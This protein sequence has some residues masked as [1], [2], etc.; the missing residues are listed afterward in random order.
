M[1][2]ILHSPSVEQNLHLHTT[3]NCT[4][5]PLSP[6]LHCG[7]PANENAEEVVAYI[8]VSPPLQA[9]LL[10]ALP[11]ATAFSLLLLHIT[12]FEH[13]PM[14]PSATVVHKRVGYHASVSLLA[15]ILH[16][17]RRTLRVSDEILTDE[18][19][20]GAAIFF[21]QVDQEGIARIAERISRNI[22]ILQA[23]TVIPP[24]QH[25]TEIVLG[26]GSYPSPASSLEALLYYADLLQEKI[27]F[28]P[29]V[30]SQ[31]VHV[32]ASVTN[33][34]QPEK[35]ARTREPRQHST[36]TNSIPFMQL[37]TRLPTR[38]KQF[39]PYTLAL[40]LRCAPVGRDHNRLT[41]AMANPTDSLALCC[42]RET[43]GMV[44]FP[45]SCE[46]AALEML[47]A[48]NW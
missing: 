18:Q 20:T 3:E 13:I 37:P 29:A 34:R 11:H 24:L 2:E 41:V 12:Q 8:P 27:T 40:E 33:I 26:F 28:R 46:S 45:V 22:H 16:N 31:P 30:V 32:L 4:C 19:G 9:A 21:P 15:Q 25:E 35:N 1:R 48:S 17:I 42:L 47:L 23:E 38:L 7:N 6:L 5:Q 36:R 44:I 43:T 39:I 14:P 10:A